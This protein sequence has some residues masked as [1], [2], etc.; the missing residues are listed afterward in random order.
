MTSYLSFVV[1][2]RALLSLDFV[3]L[4]STCESSRASFD[5]VVVDMAQMLN[6]LNVILCWGIEQKMIENRIFV[7]LDAY[8]LVFN[9]F[10]C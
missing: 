3:C 2:S 5:F 1:E 4:N 6:L 10:I 8:V 9:K 7:V